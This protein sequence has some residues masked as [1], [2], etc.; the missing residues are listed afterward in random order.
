MK[1]LPLLFSGL[2]FIFA[3]VLF[4]LS[5]GKNQAGRE[6]T[7]VENYPQVISASDSSQLLPEINNLTTAKVSKVID[8]DTIELENGQRVRYIG[9]DTPETVDPRKPVQCFGQ[10]SAAKN[11]E[12]VEGKSISLEKDVSQTDKY[13]RLLRYVYLPA[14]EAGVDDIFVNDYL[15]KEGFAQSSAF[16]PDIKYQDRLLQSQQRAQEQGKGLWSVC[17]SDD[18]TT[19]Q[20]E[21]CLIKGNISTSGEKIYHLPGQR[22]Y[23]KTVVDE[24]KGE[25]WFC[26]EGEAQDSGW[27]KSKL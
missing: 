11:K 16:P 1:K 2:F 14:G 5:F 19:S 18:K 10:E 7:T 8:G 12:L 26:T 17:K 24:S 13:G 25:K 15:V 21:A 6:S 9:I 4:I 22:Y 23:D 20:E 27:R 3:L